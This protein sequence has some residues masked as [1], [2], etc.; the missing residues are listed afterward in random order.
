MYVVYSNDW[1]R[2]YRQTRN[3][4]DGNVTIALTTLS[5]NSLFP[6]WS[7]GIIG[8]IHPKKNQNIRPFPFE[9]VI[10]F[11]SFTHK[12]THTHTQPTM[13]W[14]RRSSSNDDDDDPQLISLSPL[15]HHYRHATEPVAAADDDAIAAAPYDNTEPGRNGDGDG[16]G[17]TDDHGAALRTKAK[18]AAARDA[19]HFGTLITK[20][21]QPPLPHSSPATTVPVAVNGKRYEQNDKNNN[22]N[23]KRATECEILYHCVYSLRCIPSIRAAHRPPRMCQRIICIINTMLMRT[24]ARCYAV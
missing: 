7:H 22:N 13:K 24:G 15:P 2:D 23:K 4:P 17:D 10:F 19:L 1:S 16:D 9:N 20:S 21:A 12:N 18:V 6:L 14:F 5:H 11:V 3:W 8:H